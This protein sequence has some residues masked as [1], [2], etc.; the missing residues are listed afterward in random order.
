MDVIEDYVLKNYKSYTIKE[1]ATNL[2]TT[3]SKIKK[4]FRKKQLLS[5]FR[6]EVVFVN[7]NFSD[8][9]NTCFK[10]SVKRILNLGLRDPEAVF[11]AAII[12]YCL[13]TYHDINDSKIF[14]KKYFFENLVPI[15]DKLV[16]EE[17]YIT[18]DL[19]NSL[20][21]NSKI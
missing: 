20:I 4:V 11:N 21:K 18:K 5:P 3:P 7:K 13:D 15:L 17:L 1:L 2:H 19:I 6:Y 9:S 8:A 10:Y 14:F 16:S 12:D